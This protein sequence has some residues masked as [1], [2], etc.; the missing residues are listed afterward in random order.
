VTDPSLC[1]GST[2]C[3]GRHVGRQDLNARVAHACFH[4]YDNGDWTS[5]F[6]TPNFYVPLPWL[7]P[8]WRSIR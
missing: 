6:A 5:I 1:F 2:N 4:M 3:S 7:K 8:E